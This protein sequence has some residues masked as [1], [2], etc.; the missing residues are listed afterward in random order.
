MAT[1]K[2]LHQADGTKI[3]VTVR[4]TRTCTEYS[5]TVA[6]QLTETMATEPIDTDDQKIKEQ[7]RKLLRTHYFRIHSTR[8]DMA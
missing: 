6:L 7:K 2:L 8:P 4:C 5:S 3:A 1:R